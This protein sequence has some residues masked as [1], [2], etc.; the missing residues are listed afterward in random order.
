MPLACS[1]E[2]G[3]LETVV[4]HGDEYE[5]SRELLGRIKNY[6]ENS[7]Q[8]LSVEARTP[9]PLPPSLLADNRASNL[10]SSTGR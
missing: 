5:D 8:T 6:F 2:H 9:F 3:L 1:N 10:T 7:Y 4:V